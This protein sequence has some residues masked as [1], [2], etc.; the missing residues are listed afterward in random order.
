MSLANRIA[1]ALTKQKTAAEVEPL[2]EEVRAAIT[3]AEVDAASHRAMALD[4]TATDDDVRTARAAM[5]DAQF[6]AD[7]LKEAEK[8]IA[9][10]VQDLRQA[11]EEARRKAQADA[12]AERQSAIRSQFEAEYPVLAQR[13]ASLAMEMEAAGLRQELPKLILGDGSAHAPGQGNVGF[14]QRQYWPVQAEP[15][16]K[17]SRLFTA[18]LSGTLRIIPDK[19][20]RAA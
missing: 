7:R 12:L 1:E 17:P 4:P 20:A 13:I 15:W 9:E 16:T 3:A 2:I 10:R 6:T 14:N 19:K 5:E 18:D 11:E 8:R